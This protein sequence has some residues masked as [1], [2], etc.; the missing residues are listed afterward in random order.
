MVVLGKSLRSPDE[1]SAVPLPAAA[2]DLGDAPSIAA[3]LAFAIT[4]AGGVLCAAIGVT[5]MAAWLARATAVLRF[6]SQNP[7]AFNSALALAVTGAALVLVAA[8]R[9]WAA[10]AAGVLDAAFGVAVLTEY[11]ANRSLGI[12]RLIVRPYLSAPGSVPE[13]RPEGSLL[14]FMEVNRDITVRKQDERELRRAAEDIRVLNAT[15][16]QRVQQRTEHLEQANCDLEAFAYS[17]AHDLRTPLRGISGFAEALLEDYGDRLDETGRGYAA[18]VQAGCARMA[19]LID[20]LLD[21]SRVIRANRQGQS[22]RGSAP[23]HR[24]AAC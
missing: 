18:R 12:D 14:G 13:R 4:V 17:T 2:G 9:S 16:E 24:V 23:G 21:L 22:A 11:L 10:L 8:R 7:M 1:V 19:S 3:P 6:G 15:L 20:D 5:V